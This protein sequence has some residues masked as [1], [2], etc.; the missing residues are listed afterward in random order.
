MTPAG[1]ALEQIARA[2]TVAS[3]P[4]ILAGQESSDG[5]P[6]RRWE[7]FST[8]DVKRPQAAKL[9]GDLFEVRRQ[10]HGRLA[11]GIPRAADPDGRRR[12]SAAGG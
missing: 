7:R 4:F 6:V 11:P 9:G 2:F 8:G 3:K 10:Q 5:M 1:P 12:A